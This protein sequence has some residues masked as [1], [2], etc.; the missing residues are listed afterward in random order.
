M[1]KRKWRTI[2]YGKAVLN[3]S[4]VHRFVSLQDTT[5]VVS[6]ISEL[7]NLLSFGT[8]LMKKATMKEAHR[9]IIAL[10][11][12]SRNSGRIAYTSSVKARKNPES[13]LHIPK[14]LMRHSCKLSDSDGSSGKQMRYLVSLC[15][16]AW[17]NLKIQIQCQQWFLWKLKSFFKQL[18]WFTC[19]EHNF[20][21]FRSRCRHWQANLLRLLDSTLLHHHLDRRHNCQPYNST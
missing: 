16:C 10:S 14:N 7:K 12:K 18:N 6:S 11:C 4:N 9:D 8:P 1:L 21:R 3:W 15:K 17:Q 20:R 19:Q 5:H 13:T 2:T